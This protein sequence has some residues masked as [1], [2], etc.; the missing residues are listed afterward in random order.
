MLGMEIL[1]GHATLLHTV[2]ISNLLNL[3]DFLSTE[4][5]VEILWR[6]KSTTNNTTMT[7]NIDPAAKPTAPSL[8]TQQ[9]HHQ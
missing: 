5:P 8:E 7:L 6:R 3:K 2:K 4:I 1:G 9:G